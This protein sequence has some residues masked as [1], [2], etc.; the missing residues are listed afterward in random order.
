MYRI[1]F[2]LLS[3]LIT[4]NATKTIHKYTN[5]LIK[6]DSPY[7]LQHAHNP[8]NWYSWNNSTFQLAKKQNKLLFVSVGYSTCHWCHVMEEESFED[9]YI[10][11]LLNDDYI[12]IK[13]D[14]EELP[15]IDIA[16][17][18]ILSQLTTRRNGWPLNFILTPKE[19]IVYISSYIPATLKYGVEGMDTLIPRIAKEYKQEDKEL[20]AHIE[21]NKLIIKNKRLLENKEV[22]LNNIPLKF[23]E[24]MKNRYDKLY[25]GFD[26]SPKFPLSSNL[27]FLL[28]IYLLDGNKDALEMV[29]ESLTYMAYGGVYDQIEYGFFRYSVLSDWIIPHFEKMLYTTAQLIPVYYKAY[30][31]TKKQIYK[32]T[33]EDSIISMNSTFRNKDGLYFSA[34]DADSFND[35]KEKEEGVYFVY[36]PQEVKEKF[37]QNGFSNSEE[38]LEYFGL[39][40]FGNFE[41]GLSNIYFPYFDEAQPK[42]FKKALLLLKK[43]RVDRSKPFVD[44]KILT[45]W[46]SMMI[47]SIFIAS[48]LNEK[49]LDDARKSLDSLLDQM[50]IDDVLYHQKINNKV[51]IKAGIDDYGYLVDL[52]LQSYEITFDKQYLSLAIKLSE[53]TIKKFYNNKKW[54]L[55]SEKKYEVEFDDKHYTASISIVL[56]NL[57]SIANITY[58]QDKLY[59]AKQLIKEQENKILN[60]IS[61]AAEATRA[62]VRVQYGD[63]IL[64]ANKQKLLDSLTEQ[65][66]ITYPFVLKTIE[67]TN[68]FLACD[69]N[70]CFSYSKK[71]ADVI[72]DINKK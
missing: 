72:K 9:E 15:H 37:I 34:S 58:N 14:K 29:D 26:K 63:V 32:K 51:T 39:D 33:I 68:M 30:K 62:I 21:L 13:V 55:T 44:K 59:Q 47:K 16:Y 18:K 42:N 20:Y 36:D 70:T 60:N 45:S 19:E 11:K 22:F 5:S 31:I 28:D 56:H 57:L 52:L 49:Y 43:M 23:V 27:N 7:L 67:K 17:Q 25:K 40:E 50:Y 61:A 64:K 6:E 1:V 69:E 12:S 41:N 71:L 3:L 38:L 8:V 66:T 53:E 10:A 35:K 48:K 2:L 65:N 46:N 54:Y 24:S 4:L